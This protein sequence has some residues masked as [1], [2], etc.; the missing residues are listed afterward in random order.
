[1]GRLVRYPT[2]K[3]ADIRVDAV[4][5]KRVA[6]QHEHQGDHHELG[7]GPADPDHDFRAHA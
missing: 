6:A 2:D 1:M 7:H 4:L 5:S 3:L